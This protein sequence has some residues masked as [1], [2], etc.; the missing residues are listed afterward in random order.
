MTSQIFECGNVKLQSGEVLSATQIAYRTYG[1]PN[2]DASNA[3]LFPTWYSSRDVQNEWLIGTGRPLDPERWFI[4]VPNLIGNGLSTSPSNAAPPAD[5]GRFPRVTVYDNVLLQRRLLTERLGVDRIA[6]AIGRSMGAMQAFQWACLFPDKVARLLAITGAAR[7]SPHNYVFLA[8]LKAALT[9]DPAW[10]GGD[11]KSPPMTG[12]RAFGRVYA[13]WI[14]SQA[15]YRQHCY[16]QEVEASIEGF[17]EAKWDTNFAGR[18]ANNLLSQLD[19][20]QQGDISANP[21]FH[22]D[23][24]RALGAIKARSIVMP[25]RSDLYFPPEDS[26]GEVE[27]MPEAELRVLPSI[28]GHRAGGPNSDPADIAFVER[29]IADLLQ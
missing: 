17:L 5:K 6:L 12:L 19:T 24:D 26:A 10:N 23:F 1:R 8:G 9:A 21:V 14:Y 27:R 4:I 15:W 13:G 20:W 28:G 22:G 3:I 16:R 2:A 25:C 29:A 11:Y 7:V 18:D